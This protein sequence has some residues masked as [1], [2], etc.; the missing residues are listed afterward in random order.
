MNWISIGRY[1]VWTCVCMCDVCKYNELR[2][3]REISCSYLIIVMIRFA[4]IGLTCMQSVSMYPSVCAATIY[5]HRAMSIKTVYLAKGR[6]TEES[7]WI[8]WSLDKCRS[9]YGV[10]LKF[11]F[12]IVVTEF[13][14][15][16]CT[17][18]HH[19]KHNIIC[20]FIF[21]Y[22]VYIGNFAMTPKLT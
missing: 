8:S 7:T 17:S 1:P 9:M 12:G 4:L 16:K 3:P 19:T 20:T 11:R 10:R 6:Q 5:N 2:Q 22:L 13:D 18:I 15:I 14:G 21:I